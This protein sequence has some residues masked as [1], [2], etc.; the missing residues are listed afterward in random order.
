[1]DHKSVYHMIAAQVLRFGDRA[2]LH[3]K[4]GG[5]WIPVSWNELSVQ[6]GNVSLALIQLGVKAGEAVGIVSENK[7]EWIYTDLGVIGSGAVTTA[8]YPTTP[9]HDVAYIIGHAECPVAFAENK[10]QLQKIL[11]AIHEL[12]NLRKIIVYGMAGV[13][14]DEKII[15]FENFIASGAAADQSVRDE[16]ERRKNEMS[17]ENCVTYIYT[18]GTT[19]P[20]KG[21]MLTH[22]NVLF[23]CNALCEVNFVGPADKSLSFLPLAHALERIVTCISLSAG[24]EI[25]MAESI[26][27]LR[28]NLLEVRPTILIGV[29][30]VYEKIYDGVHAEVE[31]GTPLKKRIFHRSLEIGK[32]VFNL[33]IRKK[34]VPAALALKYAIAD[35]LVLKKIRALAGGR[36]RF[37]G[38]GG[39]PLPPEVQE[40]FCAAGMQIV[41]AYG[42]T[43]TCAPSILTPVN[44]SRIGRVGKR[45]KGVDVEIAPDGEIIIRGPNL[46]KGYFKN[47]EATAAAFENGWFKSG[48]LGRFDEEGYLEITGRKKDLLITS[49]GKN[50]SPQNLEQHFSTLP[51]VS[52]VVICG[53]N[54]PYL[55]ALFTLNRQEVERFAVERNIKETHNNPLET[56]PEVA[57]FLQKQVDIKNESVAK[58]EKVK[59][60]FIIPHEFSVE[61]G[62][63]T[64]TMKI[65]RNVVFRNFKKEINSMY[66]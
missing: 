46:F 50:I 15:S 24:G 40:F 56:N 14:A 10:M 30:R 29:P 6:I 33:R 16:W 3:H 28:E 41:Q 8:A 2:V 62:E 61:S 48:D 17:P 4:T 35:R 63:M 7:V 37:L 58:F 51:L 59:K 64:P 52:Q 66:E 57:A 23:I 45:M 53:D 54:R 65:K 60:F 11:D 19:G 55:S 13:V 26:P 9:S 22:G 44:E 49:G 18:S 1:M 12:P 38:S 42:L 47:D 5:R 39:A 31:K 32:T 27:K 25:Y 21:A 36:I 34:R 20:P 43:E